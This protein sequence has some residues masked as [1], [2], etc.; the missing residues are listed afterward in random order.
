MKL[1]RILLV[2]SLIVGI[3]TDPTKGTLGVFELLDLRKVLH[4]PFLSSYEANP[5]LYRYQ[6]N[7]TTRVAMTTTTSLSNNCELWMYPL[8]ELNTALRKHYI[9]A[10]ES[11]VDYRG[12][13]RVGFG[14]KEIKHQPLFV[15]QQDAT[16]GKATSVKISKALS[17]SYLEVAVRIVE[18][19]APNIKA[20]MDQ[21]LL[22]TETVSKLDNSEEY[23]RLTVINLSDAPVN[24]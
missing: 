13:Y 3:M 1:A 20:D 16:T 18:Q 10:I 7:R 4:E 9:L 21:V 5:Q 14:N 6:Y 11:C 12:N 2:I 23:E 22:S 24:G 19:F 15:L 8:S 17:F